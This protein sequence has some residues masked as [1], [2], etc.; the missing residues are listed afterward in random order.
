MAK[1]VKSRVKVS[2][3]HPM[4]KTPSMLEPM[5]TKTLLTNGTNQTMVAPAGSK[6]DS[7]RT[8]QATICQTR[9]LV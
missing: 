5:F 2:I 7:P 9:T 8:M 1:C 4:A 3:D 6:N